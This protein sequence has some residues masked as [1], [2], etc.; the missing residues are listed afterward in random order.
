MRRSQRFPSEPG[1]VE[2]RRMRRRTWAAE[3]KGKGYFARVSA[4]QSLRYGLEAEL[5]RFC[6]EMRLQAL[7][8]VVPQHQA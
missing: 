4:P 7:T 3:G 2:A 8:K 5:L 6:T 1:Q